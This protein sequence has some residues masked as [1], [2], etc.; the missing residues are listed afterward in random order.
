VGLHTSDGSR[1][2][3][4][5]VNDE[6]FLGVEVL[7]NGDTY[8]GRFH[9]QQRHGHGRCLFHDLR[10]YIGTWINGQMSGDGEMI[11]PD[12]TTF[13]GQHVDGTQSGLG[14]QSWPDGRVYHGEWLF[15]KQ[16]GRGTFIDAEGSSWAPT[17]CPAHFFFTWKL[18]NLGATLV[19]LG[20]G[21][22]QAGE[23]LNGKRIVEKTSLEGSCAPDV[24]SCRSPVFGQVSKSLTPSARA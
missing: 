3:G 1:F 21:S 18:L 16:H 5:F 9:E 13:K 22:G 4:K 23:W 24:R 14:R 7:A 6:L 11:W 17:L 12:G 19:R 20:F 2:E 10:E 8:E 15:G